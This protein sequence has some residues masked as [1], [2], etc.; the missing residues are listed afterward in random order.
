MEGGWVPTIWLY[1]LSA[2]TVA[3]LVT[4][5]GSIVGLMTGLFL[6]EALLATVG[7]YVLSRILARG[8]QRLLP[9]SW[10]IG[11]IVAALAVLACISLVGVYATPLVAGG[12]RVNLLQL[13]A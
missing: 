5:G 3:V 8:L 2:F 12:G 7:L 10:R 6:V 9:E 11:G 13:F 1:E 4:E